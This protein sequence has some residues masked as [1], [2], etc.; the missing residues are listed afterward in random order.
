[1]SKKEYICKLKSCK[2]PFLAR[3]ADRARGWA[4]FCSKS[5]KAKEQEYKT[6]QY[7]HMKERSQQDDIDAAMDSLEYGWDGHKDIF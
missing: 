7:R 5:C 3:E 1:M 4:L 2:T 6:G